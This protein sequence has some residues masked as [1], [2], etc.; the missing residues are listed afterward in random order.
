MRPHR[1]RDF[2]NSLLGGFYCQC[3]RLDRVAFPL[4]LKCESDDV[5]SSFQYSEPENL[6]TRITR[7]N[8]ACWIFIITPQELY[9]LGECMY[10]PKISC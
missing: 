8:A 7:S 10:Y 9:A 5:L 1:L 3:V 6:G 2:V 4:S